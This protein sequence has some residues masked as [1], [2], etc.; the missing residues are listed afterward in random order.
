MSESIILLS[1]QGTILIK[2]QPSSHR[3]DEIY[4]D[5]HKLLDKEDAQVCYNV[6]MCKVPFC[7]IYCSKRMIDSFDS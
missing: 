3:L 2:Q 4:V 6:A 5:L 7:C 1:S